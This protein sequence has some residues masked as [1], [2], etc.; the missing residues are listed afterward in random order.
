MVDIDGIHFVVELRIKINQDFCGGLIMEYEKYIGQGLN[1]E[2]PLKRINPNNYCMDCVPLNV[3]LTELLLYR[4][5]I[6]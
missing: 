5:G 4:F 2:S 3:D 6:T 1:R